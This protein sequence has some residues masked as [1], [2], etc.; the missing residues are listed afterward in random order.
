MGRVKDEKVVKAL[1]IVAPLALA[2]AIALVT[3]VAIADG[4]G[5][6]F[7]NPGHNVPF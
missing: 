3:K 6:G 7:P 4:N 1:Y 5:G 2:I